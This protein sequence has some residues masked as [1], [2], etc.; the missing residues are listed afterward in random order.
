MRKIALILSILLLSLLLTGCFVAY[1]TSEN[2]TV[3]CVEIDEDIDISECGDCEADEPYEPYEPYEPHVIIG[4]A[5]MEHP[6]IG[7]WRLLGFI[8][9]NGELVPIEGENYYIFL[10]GGE[11]FEVRQGNDITIS[12]SIYDE[13]LIIYWGQ[14]REWREAEYSISSNQ[15]TLDYGPPCQEPRIFERVED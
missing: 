11:G 12:W 4:Y 10:P 15:L 8:S 9:W 14:F 5:P 2:Y 7:R 13:D 3:E 1:Q 6:I